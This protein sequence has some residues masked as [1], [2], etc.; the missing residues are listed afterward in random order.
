MKNYKILWK[1]RSIAAS[2]ETSVDNLISIGYKIELTAA[3]IK[4]SHVTC[5]DWNLICSHMYFTLTQISFTTLHPPPSFFTLICSLT[6]CQWLWATQDRNDVGLETQHYIAPGPVIITL[7]HILHSDNYFQCSLESH[8]KALRLKS[9]LW[10]EN[11]SHSGNY[12]EFL[13]NETQI[14]N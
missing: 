4:L 1:S 6:Q 5:L 10:E 3:I 13:V 2:S 11:I 14:V 7:P 9:N 8:L 12:E